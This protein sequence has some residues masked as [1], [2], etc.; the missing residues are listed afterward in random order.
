MDNILLFFTGYE[1]PP[2][3]PG[4]ATI[5]CPPRPKNAT[6]NCKP[7]EQ[8]CLFNIKNDPCEFYNIAP[9]NQ[10]EIVFMIL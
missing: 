1:A 4:T 10:G 6:T 2:Y 3:K 8:P 9:W 5:Y 7:T